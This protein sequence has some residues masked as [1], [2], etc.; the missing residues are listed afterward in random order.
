MQTSYYSKYKG[1]NAVSIS[2]SKPQ[3]YQKCREY[4]KKKVGI[5]M[6]L[7]WLMS[8]TKDKQINIETVNT[9]GELGV[10]I[11]TVINDAEININTLWGGNVLSLNDGS[12]KIFFNKFKVDDERFLVFYRD[13]IEM[14]ILNLPEEDCWE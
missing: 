10:N 1:F 2:L 8:N 6:D 11:S 3:W 14:V 7:E 12:I 13:N 4:K 5:K 9:D